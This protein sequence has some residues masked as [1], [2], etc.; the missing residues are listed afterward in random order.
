MNRRLTMKTILKFW[1]LL[2]TLGLA[3]QARAQGPIIYRGSAPVVEGVYRFTFTSMKSN[4]PSQGNLPMTGALLSASW[5]HEL[6]L[7]SEK[8]QVEYLR[9]LRCVSQT[10]R[11]ADLLT[12][13][14]GPVFYAV[15]RPK[16]DVHVQVML[17]GARETRGELQE[18]RNAGARIREP[19]GICGRS[20]ISIPGHGLFVTEA[21]SGVPAHFVF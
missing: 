3:S 1:L 12:Y 9:R 5:G 2:V 4:V 8:L 18:R 16:F 21:R 20:G 15:R 7:W 19:L 11:N 10:G 13:M 6:T 17:G 14:G